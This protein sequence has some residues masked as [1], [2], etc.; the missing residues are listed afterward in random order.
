[1]IGY[2][3]NFLPHSRRARQLVST[4]EL[5]E[6]QYVTASFSSDVSGFLGGEVGPDNSP[7]SQFQVHGP[8]GAYNRLDLLGGGEGHLQVTHIAGLMFFVTGLR[9][10]QVHAQMRNHGLAVDLVDAMTVAF[11]G[12]AVGMVG[13]TGNAGR[14]YRLALTVY[15]EG[16][17]FL[18]DTMARAALIRR[19][20]G[21]VE[22]LLELQRPKNR[23]FVTHNFVDTVLGLTENGCPGEIGWRTVELLDAA[24]RSASQNG[25]GVRVEDLYET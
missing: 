24:Y 8:S 15:C 7:I 12:E 9:A 2:T 17:C 1:M 13:G 20:D 4:G 23:Y 5:G 11:E 10:S 22:D 14:N 25:A 21:T 3:Y 19:H 18:A 6:V 16:G